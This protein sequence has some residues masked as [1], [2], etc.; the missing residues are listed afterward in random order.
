[1]MVS[2]IARLIK[3]CRKTVDRVN[4]AKVMSNIRLIIVKTDKSH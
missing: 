4:V 1:M 2:S 3:T